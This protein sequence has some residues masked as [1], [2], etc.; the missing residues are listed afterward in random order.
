MNDA[1]HQRPLGRG[2]MIDV[3]RIE[4]VL[5]CGGFGITYL[6]TDTNLNVGVA[7]K[8]YFPQTAWRDP[9]TRTV[10]CYGGEAERSYQFGLDRFYKEGQILAQFNHPNIVRVRRLLTGNGTAYLEPIPKLTH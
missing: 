2:E 10:C 9:G 3:F 6:A 1:V 7:V 8:E 5:G 4:R